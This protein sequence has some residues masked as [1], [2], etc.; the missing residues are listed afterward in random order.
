MGTTIQIIT[1]IALL[2]IPIF[3]ED[4]SI[5]IPIS[6]PAIGLPLI[7]ITAPTSSASATSIFDT[8]YLFSYLPELK[9]P[10]Q[11]LVGYNTVNLDSGDPSVV[12]TNISS[13]SIPKSYIVNNFIFNNANYNILGNVSSSTSSLNI[14]GSYNTNGNILDLEYGDSSVVDT[15]ISSLGIP[16]SYN[17]SGTTNNTVISKAYAVSMLIP[18]LPVYSTLYIANPNLAIK[19]TTFMAKWYIWD[20]PSGWFLTDLKNRTIQAEADGNI[21]E[22]DK[23]FAIYKTWADKYLIPGQPYYNQ[24]AE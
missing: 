7:D 13:L 11:V 5:E 17:G 3:A 2:T 1:L 6:P 12:D 4:V 10:N 20:P 14:P 24:Q 23:L 22:R 16:G 19:Y 18:Q 21:E 8:L 15:N 9:I